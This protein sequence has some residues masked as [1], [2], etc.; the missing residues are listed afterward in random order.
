MF[1]KEQWHGMMERYHKVFENLI[2]PRIVGFNVAGNPH[3]YR[4]LRFAL[5]SRLMN[6][7]YF[8]FTDIERGYS[9]V[10]WFDEYEVKLG[11]PL[12]PP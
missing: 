4:F 2:S 5:S 10:P 7:G 1:A 3:D 9:T 11:K 8:S 6:D 12:D